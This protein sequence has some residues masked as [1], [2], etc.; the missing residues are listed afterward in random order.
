M[1]HEFIEFL[2]KR[3]EGEDGNR[4]AKD[5]FSIEATFVYK[6]LFEGLH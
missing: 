6:I 2:Q 5:P 4:D 1:G 3:L